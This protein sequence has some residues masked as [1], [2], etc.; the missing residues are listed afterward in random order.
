MRR[1]KKNGS[2][3]VKYRVT[4]MSK[5][6]Y[7]SSGIDL[8]ISE[9]D[10]L[11]TAK[12]LKLRKD[13]ELIKEGFEKI[14]EHIE[15]LYKSE[16]GFTLEQLNLRLSRGMKNSV[17]AAF[18]YKVESLKRKNK[19]GTSE[20]Y[21][22]TAKSI[23]EYLNP[24]KDKSEVIVKD[25]KFSQVTV[26]WLKD[27]EDYLL[28]QGKSYTTISMYMRALQA[29]INEGRKYGIISQSQHPFG[30]DKYE[31]PGA[32]GRRMALTLS[33][34]SQIINYPLVSD[35]ELRCR[36]LWFFLYLSSGMNI[37]DLLSL[38]YKDIEN[39]NI[40]YFRR[41]TVS[42]SKNKK[43]IYVSLLPEMQEII[44][45]WGNP[46]KSPDYYI[47]PILND[48]M[49][50]ES[51]RR[52]VKSMTAIINKKMTVIGKS[53]G[54][55]AISTYTARHSFATVSKRLGVNTA[56]ISEA[57]GHSD[58]KTTQNYLDSFEDETRLK[59]AQMLIPK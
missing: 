20:W 23:K 55:G 35:T 26:S 56:Y 31:I 27:Y 15:D 18:D 41:K 32:E 6:V 58:E 7:Y 8:S 52:T 25:L 16:Q 19:I 5:Q 54:F 29:V 49:S 46:D 11:P 30:A 4:C 57:L 24:G 59:N 36:D 44:D 47:F 10:R 45:K 38:R 43:K 17:L 33:Q 48:D 12:G 9:W 13:R 28:E 14:K 37:V 40:S 50:P 2:F 51:E 42:R 34:I 22:Y 1:P 3:P 21:Y 39:G 53:L